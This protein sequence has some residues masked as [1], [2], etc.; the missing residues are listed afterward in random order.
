MSTF[1]PKLTPS[2]MPRTITFANVRTE[3]GRLNF[4]REK[5]IK[6]YESG[7]NGSIKLYTA[8]FVNILDNTII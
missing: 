6:L 4:S 3:G 8:I 1:T 5:L 2:F 7:R